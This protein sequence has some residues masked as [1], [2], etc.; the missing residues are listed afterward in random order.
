MKK[1]S[2]L[3]LAG[4]LFFVGLVSVSA[5]SEADLKAKFEETLTLR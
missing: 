3:V 2:A 5:M 1:L 4:V